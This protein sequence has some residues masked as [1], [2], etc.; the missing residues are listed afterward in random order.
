M[1]NIRSIYEKAKNVPGVFTIL[2]LALLLIIFSNTSEYFFT[3]DSMLAILL[4]ASTVSY[5][6]AGQFMVLLSGQFDM[7]VGNVAAMSGVILTLLVNAGVSVPFA[8]LLALVFGVISGFIAGVC[9]SRFNTN[10]FITTFAL[11]QIYRGILFVLTGGSTVPVQPNDAFRFLG[12]YKLFGVLQMPIVIML[13][14]F[15]FFM[16]FLKFTRMGRAIYCVGNNPEAAKISGINVPRTITFCFLM[17]GFF[18]ALSGVVFASRVNSGQPNLG[19]TYALDTIAASVIG[20]TSMAGG[21]G[22]IWGAFVGILV[23]YVIQN[24]LIMSGLDSYYHY[25][26]T[27]LIMFFAVLAQADKIRK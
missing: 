27:G 22:N 26:V 7:S 19:A 9:V 5:I 12:T 11:L 13:V 14:I 8:V 4:S 20:G 23:V 16:L 18:A 1:N 25:I 24:G 3:G 21:K 6:A 10:A 17:T 15:I 2:L